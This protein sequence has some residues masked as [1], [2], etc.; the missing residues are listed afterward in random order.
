MANHTVDMSPQVYA[1]IGGVLYLIIIAFGFFAEGYVDATL[2]VPGDPAATASNIMASQSLWRVSLAGNMIVALC[3]VALL[4]VEYMLLRPVS[5]PLVL[6]AVFF[7]LVSLAIEAISKLYLLEVASLLNDAVYAQAFA[8]QELQALA[9]LS[10]KSHDIAWNLALLFFGCTS[11][12]NGYLIF[13]SGYLP[14]AIGILLQLAGLSYLTACSAAL[15][16]PGLAALLLPAILVP[17][18]VGEASFCLWL[19]VK[20]VN[21]AEWNRRV[22]VAVSH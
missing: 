15:L 5:K 19:L 1:R 21:L 10:L 4:L 20:G 18:L 3:A 2:I 7:N 16:A 8:P 12:I 9:Y 22:G 13:K 6:L 11:L 14:K 17:V